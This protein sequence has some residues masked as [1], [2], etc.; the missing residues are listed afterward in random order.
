MNKVKELRNKKEWTQQELANKAKI[1]IR[2][3]QRVETGEVEILDC[4]LKTIKS[5]ADALGVKIEDL[6]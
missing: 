6:L 4:R 5:M 3:V 2:A 1:P